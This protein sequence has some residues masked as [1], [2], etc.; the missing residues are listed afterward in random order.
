MHFN[1]AHLMLT[2]KRVTVI[3]RPS[4]KYSY[5]CVADE[6]TENQMVLVLGEMLPPWLWVR[7]E[8]DTQARSLGE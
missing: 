5:S 2:R 1:T 8:G 4:A 6:T 7:V 3:N